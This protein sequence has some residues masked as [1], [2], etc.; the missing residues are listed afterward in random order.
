VYDGRCPIC[1]G[2]A[3]ALKIK[4]AFGDLIL[5][6][7]RE[8]HPI[9]DELKLANMNIDEGMVVKMNDVLYHGADAQ[10]ILAMIGTNEDWFNRLNVI[11][12]SNKMVAKLIYPILKQIRNLVL[13]V[14]GISKIN[15]LGKS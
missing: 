2:T 12:F 3:N 1:N 7:A 13:K 5:V 6:N 15:N 4:A 14:K 11:L 8:P 10:Y 9:M